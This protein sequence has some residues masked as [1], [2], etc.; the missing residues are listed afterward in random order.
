[1][2]CRACETESDY[3]NPDFQMWNL[4]DYFGI[5][6]SFCSLCYDKVSHDSYGRPNQPEEFLMMLL[7]LS[8]R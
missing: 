3:S 2:K 5:S 6:G 4:R 8:G 1:M 7:K